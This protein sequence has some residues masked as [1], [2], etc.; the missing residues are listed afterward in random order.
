MMQLKR[1]RRETGLDLER[2]EQIRNKSDCAD[3][4][5]CRNKEFMGSGQWM[6][7]S[8]DQRQKEIYQA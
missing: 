6:F 2:Q 7:Q 8:H 5:T 1:R 4:P 3:C